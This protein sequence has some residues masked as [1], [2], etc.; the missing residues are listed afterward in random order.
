MF[1]GGL[2]VWLD[3]PVFVVANGHRLPCWRLVWEGVAFPIW[4]LGYQSW[5]IFKTE[6]FVGA[7]SHIQK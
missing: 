5:E 6:T 1:I 7:L 3:A 2:N 4:G